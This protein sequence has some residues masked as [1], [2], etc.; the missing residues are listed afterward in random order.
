MKQRSNEQ[1]TKSFEQQSLRAA[2]HYRLATS[3]DLSLNQTIMHLNA[4][5]TLLKAIQMPAYSLEWQT[6]LAQAYFKRAEVL[7]KK[8]A[9]AQA[10]YDYRAI[11]A[12]LEGSPETQLLFS[13]SSLRI[14][15]LILQ[16]CISPT[17]VQLEHPL[18]YVNQSLASL[19]AMGIQADRGA[20]QFV[21]AQAHQIAGMSLSDHAFEEALE[22]FERAL[23]ISLGTHS[24][25]T[26]L[27]LS[28]IYQC[29]GIL[30]EHHYYS[31]P[32]IQKISPDLL[33]IAYLYFKLSFMFCEESNLDANDSFEVDDL[34]DLMA[35]LLDPNMPPLS[36]DLSLKTMDALI[37]VYICAIEKR[38]PHPTLTAAFA[39]EE[40]I[41][42]DLARHIY[43]FLLDIHQ[44]YHNDYPLSLGPIAP[45][46]Q[47][48]FPLSKN[49][50]SGSAPKPQANH[51]IQKPFKEATQAPLDNVYYLDRAP[52]PIV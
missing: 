27:L 41:L 14:A 46:H 13:Q 24:T 23:S 50:T 37:Q 45:Y 12:L 34:F 29:M 47:L 18:F 42:D 28:D 8:S 26:A 38:L 9:F 48:Q 17:D 44:Q 39:A 4:A 35:E 33:D 22:A 31:C 52:A 19:E 1:C 3:S 36:Q 15:D 20:F 5:I 11:L 25:N 32:I 43:W 49:Q 7:E 21:H 16:E 2:A 40:S 6:Q 10:V 30:Y 51:P